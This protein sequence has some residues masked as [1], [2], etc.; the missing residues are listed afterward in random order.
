LPVLLLLLLLLLSPGADILNAEEKYEG[1]AGCIDI[2][3]IVGIV[4]EEEEIGE[5][6]EEEFEELEEDSVRLLLTGDHP[7]PS[8]HLLQA[9]C[10][11]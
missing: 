10:R 9:R 3:G 11:T 2:V 1:N 4:E 6:I 7:I 8:R 5:E